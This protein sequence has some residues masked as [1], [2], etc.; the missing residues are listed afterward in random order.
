MKARQCVFSVLHILLFSSSHAVP[1]TLKNSDLINIFFYSHNIPAL[2]GLREPWL[3]KYQ[4]EEQLELYKYSDRTR[5]QTHS[6]PLFQFR[7]H[8]D[9]GAVLLPY[10]TPE[11]WDCVGQWS[12]RTK[13]SNINFKDHNTI[14]RLNC[15]SCESYRIEGLTKKKVSS[16]SSST[17]LDGAEVSAS[18]W[19]SGDPRFQSHPRLTFQ[20]CSR[21]QLNQLGSK[22]ASESTFKRRI[23]AG[24]QIIDF[25]HHHHHHHLLLYQVKTKSDKTSNLGWS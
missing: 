17:W 24:Y 20:S 14:T 11:I 16:P 25:F 10:H 21:Y 18:G 12:L 3:I 4:F 1:P 22:A 5:N 7:H 13:L 8:H 19:G 9:R 2:P 23:L 15:L 6:I